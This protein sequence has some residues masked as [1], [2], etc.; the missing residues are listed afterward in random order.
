MAN[1][2]RIYIRQTCP[3]PRRYR[4][5]FDYPVDVLR[6]MLE[7]R[8]EIDVPAPAQWG[9]GVQRVAQQEG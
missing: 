3:R 5:L 8:V 4:D 2:I 1:L 6:E 7:N 9:S